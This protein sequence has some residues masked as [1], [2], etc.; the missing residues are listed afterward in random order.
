MFR[1]RRRESQPSAQSQPAEEVPKRVLPPSPFHFP[2][3]STAEQIRIYSGM[4]PNIPNLFRGG[5]LRG[6]DP[7]EPDGLADRGL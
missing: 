6:D 7:K 2:E 4:L 1:L 5:N 3:E